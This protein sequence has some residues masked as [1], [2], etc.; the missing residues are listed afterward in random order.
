MW[1]SGQLSSGIVNFLYLPI[2]P[3]IMLGFIIFPQEGNSIILVVGGLILV[4][5]GYFLWGILI[6][7]IIDKRKSMKNK[8]PSFNTNSQVPIFY[9]NPQPKAL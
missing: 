4:F 2:L 7:Y 3:I 5:I 1:L 8:V 9:L 6:S